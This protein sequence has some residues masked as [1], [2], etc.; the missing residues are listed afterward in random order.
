MPKSTVS[1]VALKVE[2]VALE[3]AV[4]ARRAVAADAHVVKLQ[5]PGREAAERPHLQ[6]V[7]VEVLLGDAVAHDGDHVAVL[8]EE[9]GRGGR[10]PGRPDRRPGTSHESDAPC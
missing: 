4:A 5:L 6:V 3:A 7:A 9:V 1:A 8:E 2:H 10:G